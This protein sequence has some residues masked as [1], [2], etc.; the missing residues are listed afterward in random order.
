MALILFIAIPSQSLAKSSNENTENKHKISEKMKNKKTHK[1]KINV[2]QE[3]SLDDENLEMLEQ[4]V[5][6]KESVI[7][8]HLKKDNYELSSSIYVNIETRELLLN[9]VKIT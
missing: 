5:S 3:L 6:S 9:M 2:L 1:K 4:E 8:S 7:S